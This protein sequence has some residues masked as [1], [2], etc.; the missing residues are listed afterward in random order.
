MVIFTWCFGFVSDLGLCLLLCEVA[1]Y[2][3]RVAEQGFGFRA[4]PMPDGPRRLP[5]ILK[6]A[7][8]RADRRSQARER[9]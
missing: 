7:K 3:A 4:L 9:V 2:V 1:R 5:M 8:A 6:K